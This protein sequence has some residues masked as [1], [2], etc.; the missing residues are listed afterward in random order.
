MAPESALT[1]G[2][3]RR[4]SPIRIDALE[5]Y[6][7]GVRATT[8][9]QKHRLLT[10][11]A[12]LAPTF[13]QPCFHLGRLAFFTQKNYT[14]ATPPGSR[15]SPPPASTTASR[16][17]TSASAAST[18]ANFSPPP[19][20]CANSP[21]SSL[22]EVLNNLRRRS[23]PPELTGSR[24]RFSDRR[25]N[26]ADPDFHFNLGYALWRKGD[27]DAAAEALHAA[28]QRNPDDSTATILLGRSI[29][30]RARAPANSARP[31]NASK[32][33]TTSPP[34]S[35][36]KPCSARKRA[37]GGPRWNVS[38]MG[39]MLFRLVSLPVCLAAS[40]CAQNAAPAP[41]PATPRPASAARMATYAQRN[42][43]VV[44][45]LIDT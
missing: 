22:P 42:E 35:P 9:D 30:R 24:R 15:K 16:S 29:K 39:A 23:Q 41:K 43:N 19:P 40:L 7:R 20:P 14:A 25:R 13:S 11:A 28:L 34:C 2:L 33:T 21:P 10:T 32:P 1:E 6:V 4:P 3:P 8:P 5:N 27:F 44:V 45:Y 26:P 12:R 38:R 37:V 36:S 18:Q 31:R 17:S